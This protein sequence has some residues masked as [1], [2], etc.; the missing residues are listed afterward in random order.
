MK[1]IDSTLVIVLNNGEQEIERELASPAH[2]L[3]IALLM[4][5][6]LGRLEIGDVLKVMASNRTGHQCT[7]GAGNC[8]GTGLRAGAR[9]GRAEGSKFL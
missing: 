7:V 9:A 8:R 2:A 1:L 4:L 3:R 5:A 6:R